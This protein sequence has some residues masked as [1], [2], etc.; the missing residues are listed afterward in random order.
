MDYTFYPESN[1]NKKFKFNSKRRSL[2]SNLPEI[3]KKDTFVAKID[4]LDLPVR[5]RSN[6]LKLENELRHYSD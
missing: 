3:Q 4:E 5:K 2:P 6:H 1:K